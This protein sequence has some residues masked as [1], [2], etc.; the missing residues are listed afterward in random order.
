MKPTEDAFIGS[1]QLQQTES[2]MTLNE[3]VETALAEYGMTRSKE[4]ERCGRMA[5]TLQ[6]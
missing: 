3:A 1:S 6:D 5:A 4:A 2:H